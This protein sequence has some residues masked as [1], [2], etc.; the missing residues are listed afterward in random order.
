MC[1]GGMATAGF[2]CVVYSV[3]SDE[4]ASFTGTKPAVRS[5]EI[6]NGVSKVVGPL[7]NNEG[8]QNHQEFN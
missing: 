2:E 8:R 1:A 6:P 4:I 3:G 7:L 5:A